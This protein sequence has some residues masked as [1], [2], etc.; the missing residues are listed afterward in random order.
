[1]K[2]SD[3]G[4]PASTTGITR[5]HVM[6]V[7]RYKTL[8]TLRLNVNPLIATTPEGK[9]LELH[10]PLVV[11]PFQWEIMKRTVRTTDRI[12]DYEHVKF[13]AKCVHSG[14]VHA[15]YCYQYCSPQLGHIAC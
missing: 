3:N 6:K 7:S 13:V 15:Q 12:R 1:M 5:V 2:C 8:P 4:I 11:A 9:D 14:D 10:F